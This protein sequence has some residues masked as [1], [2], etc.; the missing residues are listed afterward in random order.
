MNICLAFA[1]LL[2]VLVDVYIYPSF[3]SMFLYFLYVKKGTTPFTFLNKAIAAWI[4]ML[5][6]LYLSQSILTVVQLIM[7][8]LNSNTFWNSTFYTLTLN[9]IYTVVF[10][11]RDTLACVTIVY[12]YWHQ[13]KKAERG[14]GGSANR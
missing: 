11:L 14:K 10:P 7:Q 5:F 4:L 3:L 2:R 1:V 9:C 13:S 6:G 8:F 12:L